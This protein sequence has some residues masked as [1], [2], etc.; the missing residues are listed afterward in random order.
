MSLDFYELLRIPPDADLETIAAAYRRLVFESHPDRNNSPEATART[1]AI[2][3][4]YDTLSDPAAR[5]KYDALR[6]S[7]ESA[8]KPDLPWIV[9]GTSKL[10]VYD[11][12]K[13]KLRHRQVRWEDG[14]WSDISQHFLSCKRRGCLVLLQ[15]D[16]RL[17]RQVY[18]HG[19]PGPV[20]AIDPNKGE[21]S[22]VPPWL[23][24]CHEAEDKASAGSA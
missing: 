8:A 5:A 18:Q 16:T 1:A 14:I 15:V 21:F 22:L 24:S 2:N 20:L 19:D 3:R 13:G 23:E 12:W 9:L 17:G 6:R 4:A 7:R 10:A 11:I